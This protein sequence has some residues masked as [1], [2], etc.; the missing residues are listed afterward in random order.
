M[1]VFVQNSPIYCIFRLPSVTDR[2]NPNI[3][4]PDHI[5]YSDTLLYCTILRT[6]QVWCDWLLGNNDTWYPLVSSEPFAQLAQLATRLETVK[7]QVSGILD[8]C[9][10]EKTFLAHP[11][12]G[13]NS[14]Y[15]I[16]IEEPS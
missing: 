4:F 2:F 13:S 3:Q 10:S 6:V 5:C 11:Q 15:Q 8:L 7:T 14:E 12:G 16:K 1:E 9:L